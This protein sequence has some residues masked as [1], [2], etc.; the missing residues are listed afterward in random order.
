MLFSAGRGIAF[1][2]EQFLE[3]FLSIG[4]YIEFQRELYFSSQ[5]DFKDMGNCHYTTEGCFGI[6]F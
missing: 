2:S 4:T 6:L 5:L 3:V 1:V